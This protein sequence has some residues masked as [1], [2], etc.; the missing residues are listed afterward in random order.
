MI[1]MDD[2]RGYSA[3]QPPEK[4]SKLN[5]INY[6]NFTQ[7]LELIFGKININIPPNLISLES[8]SPLS[9]VQTI[10]QSK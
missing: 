2:A 7:S 5:P 10:N 8:T 6:Q 4:I 1:L 3:E 9:V